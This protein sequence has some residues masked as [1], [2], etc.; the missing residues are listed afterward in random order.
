[1]KDKDRKPRP[2]ERSQVACSKD[3][4]A[5]LRRNPRG[6]KRQKFLE[7]PGFP[8]TEL[9]L[10]ARLPVQHLRAAMAAIARAGG[11]VVNYASS[12]LLLVPESEL[13]AQLEI[14]QLLSAYERMRG[15]DP[16]N[17]AGYSRNP[18]QDQGT[19]DEEDDASDDEEC[20]QDE[21]ETEDDD[22]E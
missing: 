13:D 8:L 5:A 2:D 16:L 6:K 12:G 14:L 4:G 20:D 15:C 17:D 3:E 22:I 9:L 21:D 18:G 11:R 1:M 10:E 19:H 7:S